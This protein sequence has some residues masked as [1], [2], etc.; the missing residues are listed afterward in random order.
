MQKITQTNILNQKERMLQVEL[1]KY[2]MLN[3][4]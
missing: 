3:L 4:I 2:L 1:K